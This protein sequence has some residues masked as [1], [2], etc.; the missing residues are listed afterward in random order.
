M[1][2]HACAFVLLAGMT[3]GPVDETGAGLRDEVVLTASATPRV[4]EATPISFRFLT[5]EEGHEILL[6]DVHVTIAHPIQ[7]KVIDTVSNG[8]YLV[9]MVPAGRYEVVASHEGRAR[10]VALTIAPASPQSV[11]LYW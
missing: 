2:L 3:A 5:R 7:G 10:R 9:A 6:S 1:E 11:S 4:V 8:P